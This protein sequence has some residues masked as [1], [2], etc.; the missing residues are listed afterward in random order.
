MAGAASIGDFGS[1]PRMVVPLSAGL[2]TSSDRMSFQRRDTPVL[3]PGAPGAWDANIIVLPRLIPI[4]GGWRLYYNSGGCIGYAESG[5]GVVWGKRGIVL[6]PYPDPDRFDSRGV[7]TRAFLS[8]P[9]GLV[10]MY[11]AA[12][13]DSER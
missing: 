9:G 2:A 1:G 5:N 3:S 12:G 8:I 4:H 13:P 11:A 7:A 6:R 10:M